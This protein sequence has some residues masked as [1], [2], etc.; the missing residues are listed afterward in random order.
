[1]KPKTK[2]P[3]ERFGAIYINLWGGLDQ[4]GRFELPNIFAVRAK[5]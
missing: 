5:T 1:M 2:H 3:F 4:F